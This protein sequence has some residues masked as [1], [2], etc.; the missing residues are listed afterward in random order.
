MV[1]TIHVPGQ[2]VIEGLASLER[3]SARPQRLKVV[4]RV[5][6]CWFD[7]PGEGT[8]QQQ[9]V[10]RTMGLLYR[11]SWLGIQWCALDHSQQNGQVLFNTRVQH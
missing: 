10:A 2:M 5:F 7:G 3:T 4:L 6:R 9:A 1:V 8:A 11:P